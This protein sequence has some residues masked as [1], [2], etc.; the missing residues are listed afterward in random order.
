MPPQR[1]TTEN[2]SDGYG[3][4]FGIGFVLGMFFSVFVTWMKKNL[5][6]AKAAKYCEQEPKA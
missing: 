2:Y 5:E 4:V 6:F 1:L 3:Y